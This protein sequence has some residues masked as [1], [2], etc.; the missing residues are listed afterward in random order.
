MLHSKAARLKDAQATRTSR[1]A[2]I[3]STVS[4]TTMGVE[5]SIRIFSRAECIRHIGLTS[6]KL[7]P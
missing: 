1:T 3:S 2:R 4:I 5:E 7:L 6:R